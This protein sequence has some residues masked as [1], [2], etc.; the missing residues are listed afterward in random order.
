MPIALRTNRGLSSEKLGSINTIPV[1]DSPD[2]RGVAGDR[3][4]P[5]EIDE[6]SCSSS[7]SIGNNSDG[8]GESSED[9]AEAESSVKGPLDCLEVLEK[10]LPM[11]S[12]SDSS[13][14]F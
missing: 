10:D 1:F 11:R 8:G 14:P 2:E 13:N 5:A 3:R 12:E 9:E 7:S 4:H 6:D